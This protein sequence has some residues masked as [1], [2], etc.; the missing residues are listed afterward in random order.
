[1]FYYVSGKLAESQPGFAVIDCGGVGFRCSIS[2][3]TLRQLPQ[4]G[5]QATLYTYLSV[6]EDALELFG[7]FDQSELSLFK[8][9]ISVSGVGPKAAMA[10]LS[11][12]SPDQAAAAI[13]GG[14][15][16]LLTKAQGIGKKIAERIVLELKD[17]LA[18]GAPDL[19][20]GGGLPAA[21]TSAD[22]E[23]VNALLVLGY[24][25]ND[26]LEAIGRFDTTGMSLEEIIKNALKQLMK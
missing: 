26:A 10:I 24:S 17:K 4:L 14:D 8:M 25:K 23:A 2:F 21:E 11:D 15:A 22:S 20:S 19:P 9:L 12:L 16:K 7:F 13:I 18:K 3:S 6:R 5:Q 1:M